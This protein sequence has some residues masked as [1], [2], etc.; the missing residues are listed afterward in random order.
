MHATRHIGVFSYLVCA[1][2]A[3]SSR[4]DAVQGE[5]APSDGSG[6]GGPVAECTSGTLRSCNC[7]NVTQLCSAGRWAPCACD[8]GLPPASPRSCK[9]G[10]YTGD[11]SG[12][13]WSGVF[14][15]GFGSLVRVT[16][17]AKPVNGK[18]GL[19]MTLREGFTADD[20]GSGPPVY[21][22]KDG[23]LIGTAE[24]VGT[25]HPIF[26]TIT[27]QLDCETGAF[28]GTL[29]GYYYL[30][31]VPQITY[32]F[33]GPVR[34]AY[35]AEQQ[36]LADG[37]WDVKEHQNSANAPGGSGTWDVAWAGRVEDAP[38]LPPECEELLPAPERVLGSYP[39][40]STDAIERRPAR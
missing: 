11:F 5:D 17:N 22:V 23:C 34:A 15:I 3:C 27:G 14:D 10:Y 6:D 9:A 7:G 8:G 33:E 16:I 35:K 36:R 30:F 25:E 38:P 28:E 21:T 29:K 20:G 39:R 24:A 37:T 13:Y 1:L 2:C 19:G 40:S 4:P 12:E 32:K 26:G 31:G 18:P